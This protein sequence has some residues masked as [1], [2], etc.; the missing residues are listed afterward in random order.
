MKGLE[1][2]DFTWRSHLAVSASTRHAPRK[3]LEL[4]LSDSDIL[5][6]LVF[7]WHDSG[8]DVSGCLDKAP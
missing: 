2:R 8:L 7:T 6:L 4:E 5:V 1:Q 3:M